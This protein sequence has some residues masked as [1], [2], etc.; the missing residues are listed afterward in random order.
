LRPR[1]TIFLLLLSASALS[2]AADKKQLAAAI[3]AVDANLKTPAG[4]QYDEKLGS[5]FMEKH[6][7]TIRRCKQGVRRDATP[8]A[9]FDLLMKLGADGKVDDVLVFP[10]TA[11]GQCARTALLTGKFSPPPHSDYWVNVHMQF[12]Q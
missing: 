2:F 7:A 9:P 5:E 4:K 3:A 1:L 11:V 12:K 10:E 8:P 6:A